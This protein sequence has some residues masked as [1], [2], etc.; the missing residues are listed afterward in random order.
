LET[1]LAT[2]FAVV[3]LV[4][5][6][7]IRPALAGETLII[8]GSTTFNRVFLELQQPAIESA[9][10]H[11]LTVIPN[12]TRPGI[13]AVMEGRAHLAMVA[14][15][16]ETEIQA[17]RKA[18]P[19]LA[20]DQLQ[21]HPIL[22]TRVA[23]TVH[24]SNPVRHTSLAL[25]KDVLRGRITNW[26]ALGG[27]DR[28]IRVVL[29]GGGGGVMTTVESAILGGA[30]IELPNIMFIRT[31]TQVVQVVEQEPAAM[32]FA[33]LAIVKQRGAPELVTD[34]KIEQVLSFVT[35]GPPGEAAKLV[36]D[37]ARKIAE[38]QM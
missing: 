24:P 35:F 6:A 1:L 21:A 28:P 3:A 17:L 26:R 36:I 15:P 16:L 30:Q 14:A 2:A 19:G 5:G 25:I 33:Q 7:S 8:Q 20:F 13:I 34:N 12:R 27:P 9:T 29:V 32:G 31:A 10:G 11:A 18:L 23:I 4:G 22:T 37:A 38:N